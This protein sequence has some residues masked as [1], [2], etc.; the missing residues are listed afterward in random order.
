[1]GIRGRPEA[2]SPSSTTG[3]AAYRTVVVPVPLTLKENVDVAK[4]LSHWQSFER[5]CEQI[6]EAPVP[7]V[8]EFC[9]RCSMYFLAVPLPPKLE[10]TD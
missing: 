1:M 5:I 8:A 3:R 10:E 7:Q 2:R 6:V 4:L 9:A